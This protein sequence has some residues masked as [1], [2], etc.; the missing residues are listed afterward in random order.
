MFSEYTCL[1]LDGEYDK[2]EIFVHINEKGKIEYAYCWTD[3]IPTY[4]YYNKLIREYKEVK[5]KVK[6]MKSENK[7]FKQLS[8]Q[9]IVKN[10]HRIIFF[11]P[12]EEDFSNDPFLVAALKNYKQLEVY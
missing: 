8:N 3:D 10:L 5:A 1:F 7:L 6:D 2:T 9:F 4:E 12:D 11:V